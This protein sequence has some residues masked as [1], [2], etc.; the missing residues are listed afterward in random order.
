MA[1]RT[2]ARLLIDQL[3]IQG[4]NHLFCV[5]GESYLP[6]LDALIDTPIKLVVNRHES[7]STFMA[8]AYAKLTGQPGVAIVS[9]GPGA[10]NA[11]IG[12]HT[13][14]QD[15]TPLI[16]LIG[17]VGQAHSD[18]GAFQ[19]I[20]YRQLF[21]P[22]AKW[23]AQIESTARIP[24]Y[25][26]RAFQTATSG[27][28]GPVVLALP[29][30]ILSAS[31]EATD[32]QCHQPV[33]SGPS[34]LQMASFRRALG[35]A[36]RPMVILG[37]TGWTQ[38]AC[39]NVRRFAEINMLPV[40]CAFRHQDLFDNRHPNYIGDVGIGINP[41]LAQRIK[42]ADLLF[43][44]GARLDEVTT[45]GYTLIDAPNPKQT[46]IHVHCGVEELG[47]V[48]QPT[49]AIASGMPQFAA[50]LAMMMPIEAPN[51]RDAVSLGRADYEAWQSRPPVYS[52]T[53]PKL[54]L[55][56]VVDQL[57]RGLPEDT[58]IANGAGNFTTW[59][60]RFWRYSGLRTQLAPCAGSMGYGVPSGIAAKLVAP[61]RTVVVFAGDGDFL[62]SAQE[63]AT[64]VQYRAGVIFIVFNNGM[65]G[66][67]RMHQERAF[68]ERVKGT[69]LLNPHFGLLAQAYG[70]MGMVVETTDAFTPA[71]EQALIHTK[72][73]RAPAL[74]E[75]RCDP[76]IITPNA[77]IAA[78]RA[79]AKLR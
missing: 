37:G 28:Q 35:Q 79:T 75:L 23:V 50:R 57:R 39:D 3:L 10:T 68:P 27:R 15:S 51:W 63:L 4:V 16:L 26:A 32:A 18:R 29:E 77:T 76:E 61:E 44:L 49:L 13:A 66:T 36:T 30:N 62:M 21:A 48:Y 33:Q 43:V 78:I 22:M 12:V 65:Y 46:L 47:C 55:W 41:R 56:Q 58:L 24:E 20:D 2:G 38:P 67:I 45:N 72:T 14:H 34:D 60:H 25:I 19:E 11:A 42:D 52:H 8:E 17:Q 73:K 59:A 71:L 7:G 69:T 64:A 74:I 9:R 54:D 53:I 6:V 40:A 5:P 31:A 1:V 70:A